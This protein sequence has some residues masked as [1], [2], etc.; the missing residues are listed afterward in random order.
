[1]CG[2]GHTVNQRITPIYYP[3]YLTV[4][5]ESFREILVRLEHLNKY[6]MLCQ[7]VVGITR[8]TR[9]QLARMR[10]GVK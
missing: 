9:I 8:P 5:D 2:D 3:L 4:D 7:F 1:M 6:W 10:R